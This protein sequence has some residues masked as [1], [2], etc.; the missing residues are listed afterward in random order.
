MEHIGLKLYLNQTGTSYT[1]LL[2]E[3]DYMEEYIEAEG[4]KTKVIEE[5]IQTVF[6]DGGYNNA[7]E[8]C[9]EVSKQCL[10]FIRN[11]QEILSDDEFFQYSTLEEYVSM[12]VSEF[13][14]EEG[15]YYISIKKS[16]FFLV[17]LYLKKEIPYI[18]VVEDMF[19][20]FGMYE[21]KGVYTKLDPYE[22]YLCIMLELARNR[23]HGADK[24]LL[25]R[26]NGECCNNHID[27]KYNENGLCKCNEE[28]VA[29]ISLIWIKF[30]INPF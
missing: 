25:N 12:G 13:V 26:F 30:R 21:L 11:N 1:I 15:K 18:N 2:Q 27:C 16:T 20:T 6:L 7:M 4:T 10:D 28:I 3:G 29:K 22:G 8:Q 19:K 14:S 9:R 24:K 5:I 17:I 23:R